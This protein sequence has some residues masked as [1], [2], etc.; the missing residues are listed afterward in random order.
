M[1]KITNKKPI[2]IFQFKKSNIIYLENICFFFFNVNVF[3]VKVRILIHWEIWHNDDIIIGMLFCE[4]VS[5]SMCKKGY[6][7]VYFP[8]IIKILCDKFIHRG[9][10]FFDKIICGKIFFDTILRGRIYLTWKITGC[11]LL[12]QW[13]NLP[14]GHLYR[15]LQSRAPYDMLI[16]W[17]S[18]KACSVMQKMIHLNLHPPSIEAKM[19]IVIRLLL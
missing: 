17:H 5:V 3:L 6:P 10:L 8:H 19:F 9:K 13:N 11:L 12:K 16:S 18:I 15:I 4:H 14:C 1:C 7:K 2:H